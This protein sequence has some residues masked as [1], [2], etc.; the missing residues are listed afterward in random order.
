MP[1][2]NKV[3]LIERIEFV[4]DGVSDVENAIKKLMLLGT[5]GEMLA[6][7]MKIAKLYGRAVR[8]PRVSAVKMEGM[9]VLHRIIHEV[10][11]ACG[12]LT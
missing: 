4:G 8:V 3:D 12:D 5:Y 1:V 9:E 7:L 11:C 2:L 6:E 10:T